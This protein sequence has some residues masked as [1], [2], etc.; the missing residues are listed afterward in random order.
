MMAAVQ[1]FIS[2]AIS[3]CVVGETL[4]S[5][6]DGLVRIGSL[7]RGEKP[8]SFRDEVIEVASLDGVRKPDAFYYGGLRPVREV[9]LRSGRKVV[10][11]PNH[12]LLVAAAGALEL[13]GPD[14]IAEGEGVA[15]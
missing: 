14:E 5:T 15:L 13:P 12:R 9:V 10:G 7:Y 2:G 3:K 8:D 1:P 4:V 11:T 6:G